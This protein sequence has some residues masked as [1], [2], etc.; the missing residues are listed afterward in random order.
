MTDLHDYINPKTG[1]HAPLLA[2]DVFAI[3][4][5]NKD[6]SCCHLNQFALCRW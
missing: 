3:I 1:K 2:D 6:V 5:K 4:M